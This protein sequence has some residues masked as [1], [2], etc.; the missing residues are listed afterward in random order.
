MHK[1][2]KKEASYGCQAFFESTLEPVYAIATAPHQISE[3]NF[4][5]LKLLELLVI[6]GTL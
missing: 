5:K 6:I 4:K 2:L 1:N 3:G